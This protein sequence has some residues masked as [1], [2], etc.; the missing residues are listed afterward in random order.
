MKSIGDVEAEQGN[1]DSARERYTQALELYKTERNN[2][3]LANAQQ[4]LGDL[5]RK[6]R[7]FKEAVAWYKAAHGLYTDEKNKT[8]LAYTSSELARVLHATFDFAGSIHFMREAHEAAEGANLP[9]VIGYVR[10]VER[11]IRGAA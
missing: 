4:S 5:E 9:S 11:E 6:Q 8:G 10:A 3:G 2:L 7:R 1:I